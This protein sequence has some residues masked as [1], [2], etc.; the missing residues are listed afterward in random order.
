MTRVRV[1]FAALLAVA[2]LGLV[3][4]SASASVASSNP[5]FCKAASK[6]GNSGSST[7][8]FTK[9]KAKKLSA[10]FKNAAKYAPAKVKSAVKNITN[11]LNTI[12]QTGLS[13]L[14]KVYSSDAFK[15]YPSAVTTFFTYQA[16]ACLSTS[17]S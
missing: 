6:I 10:Q 17:T 9:S 13:D 11:L 14:P 15:K 8:G 3:M 16:S 2:M 7:S 12:A 5:K 4:S 1:V